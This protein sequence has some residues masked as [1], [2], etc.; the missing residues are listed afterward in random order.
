M[1]LHR[2][3]TRRAAAALEF[4]L[5]F[6]LLLTVTVTGWWAA[7]LGFVKL[8]TQIDAQ[9][10]VWSRRDEAQAGTSFDIRQPMLTSQVNLEVQREATVAAPF[11]M[12]KRPQ[13]RTMEVICDKPWH[14][15]DFEFSKLPSRIH[16]HTARLNDMGS[17]IREI[18]AF[19]AGMAGYAQLDVSKN[20]LTVRFVPE[21]LQYWIQ[22]PLAGVSMAAAAPALAISIPVLLAAEIDARANLNF[23][24]AND[25]KD[26]REVVTR[27]LQA[28]PRMLS[29]IRPD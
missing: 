12:S 19:T 17:L 15:T 11:A 14:A 29:A 13:A 18:T 21:A 16:P 20:P 4:V 7:H 3:T 8:G 9:S 6:P 22:R 26:K 10:E 27:G 5:V 24:R 2:R 25:L 28:I 23:G 1:E